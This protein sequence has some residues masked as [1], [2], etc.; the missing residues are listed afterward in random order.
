MNKDKREEVVIAFDTLDYHDKVYAY[1]K[2]FSLGSFVSC[3]MNDKL[4][5]FS[6]LA[7]VT[8]KMREKDSQI[9]PLK[10]L[11]KL[12]NQIKDNSAF[13][14]FLEAVSIIT[15]DLMYG[16]KKFDNCGMNNSQ[17]IYSKIK[18]ILNT[19]VPF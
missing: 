10:I 18:L 8:S 16:C 6:L 5:L 14:Q 12:T 9:T 4:V 19:W 2:I 15:E 13:Y 7:L 3:E 11:M 17:E 1:Q